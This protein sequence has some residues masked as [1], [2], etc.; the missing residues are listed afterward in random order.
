MKYPSLC[1]VSS[2]CSIYQVYVVV[3]VNF[4]L[5]STRYYKCQCTLGVRFGEKDLR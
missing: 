3:H 5:E 1:G 4:F 2:T